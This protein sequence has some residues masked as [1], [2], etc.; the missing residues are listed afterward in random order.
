[1]RGGPLFFRPAMCSAFAL[2]Q[3]PG[4]S[5][6]YPSV[7]AASTVLLT[8]SFVSATSVSGQPAIFAGP[9]FRDVLGVTEAPALNPGAP[10]A[11][12]SQV[13]G[14]EIVAHCN[15]SVQLS[16]FS[17][18]LRKKTAKYQP[19]NLLRQGL[20]DNRTCFFLTFFYFMSAP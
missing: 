7:D 12:V 20:Q 5:P 14:K 17:V 11:I 15:S 18:Q 16:A 8:P 19:K 13:V 9:S 10:A 3:R 6:V 2:L 1:M 4:D